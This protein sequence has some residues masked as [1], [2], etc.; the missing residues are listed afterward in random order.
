MICWKGHPVWWFGK[1]TSFFLFS[2]NSRFCG[3]AESLVRSVVGDAFPSSTSCLPP[4]F[5]LP[6]CSF[7]ILLYSHTLLSFHSSSQKEKLGIS[8][9]RF[10][11]NFEPVYLR[12]MSPS[13]SLLPLYSLPAALSPSHTRAVHLTSCFS[14]L[15]PSGCWHATIPWC[16]FLSFLLSLRVVASLC[17]LWTSQ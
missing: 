13:S 11:Q 16:L 10:Y 6:L 3:G 2:W 14:E 8:T 5:C 15:L 1:V 17:H 12:E 7:L 9:C 4:L